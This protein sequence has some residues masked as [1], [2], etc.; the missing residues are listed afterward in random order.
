[1]S[2]KNQAR[3][4]K[5][6][7]R[8]LRRRLVLGAGLV[9]LC[10]AVGSSGPQQ[11]PP[12]AARQDAQALAEE[13]KAAVAQ[14]IESTPDAAALANEA[15][16]A[17]EQLQGATER[18]A[19]AGAALTI[20]FAA[21]ATALS[22]QSTDLTRALSGMLTPTADAPEPPASTPKTMP[23]VNSG[24]RYGAQEPP[25]SDPVDS[26]RISVD[27]TGLIDL[28]VRNAD[29]PAVLEMLS[30]QTR[31]SI[32]ASQSVTGTISANLYKAT[33]T[34]ALDAL[35][36]ANGFAYIRTSG[37]IQVGTPEEIAKRLPPPETR[38][39]RLQYIPKSEALVAAEALL[40][41]IGNALAGGGESDAADKTA[42]GIATATANATMPKA[43]GDYLIVT[44]TP[45]QLEQIGAMLSDIDVRPQQVLIEATILRATLNESNEF[46]I[47]FT[48]LGGVD[49]QT[50][51]ST[52]NTSS[53]ITTGQTPP[54][55]F[56]QTTFNIN[57]DLI[58]N[59]ANGG[60]SF[61]IIKNSIGAFVRALEEVTDVAVV[62]NPKIIALNRQ[63]AEVIVGRRDGYLTTTV[64]ETAAIQTVEFLE[65]GTQIKFRPFINPNGS[66]MLAVHPKDSNGGLTSS[67][68]P[69]E[70]TTE[71]T[72]TIIVED[73][74]T[75]LIGGLFRERNVSSKGQVPILGNIPGLGMLFQ[76]AS[77]QTLREEVIILLTVHVLKNT[78]SETEAQRKLR[79]DIERVRIGSRKGLMGFG[80]ERLAQ[81]YYQEAL[82]QFDRGNRDLALLNTRMTLHNAPRHIPALKLKERL[83]GARMWDA[84]G[85]AGR[86]FLMHLINQDSEDPDLH[87]GR[88]PLQQSLD[89]PGN[90]IPG[91][92][93]PAEEPASP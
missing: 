9:A 10:G 91:L 2:I 86:T 53:D 38:I 29:L 72:A 35:V 68:L 75:V 3:R 17:F 18:P 88:P 45:E 25:P 12:P 66:V 52:S 47:D 44:D 59:F 23:P 27:E 40:S 20:D 71:A 7:P 14:A 51:A 62:A 11:A 92:A 46:G 73:G 67:N 74:H 69:F 49:F 5:P 79:E 87:L 56:E 19:I 82:K 32:V 22:S 77:D 21:L 8:P 30:Y 4:D 26:G 60:F 42:G 34:Q 37:S 80:R 70:E 48:L 50:V 39:F 33:L 43:G 28:H 24:P 85:S 16:A 90:E 64:T 63:E 54:E 78:D 76:H 93:E 81:A 57:T 15:R 31:E 36:P 83:L 65:T 13:A 1:M 89:Q 61:G 58:N 55:K 84:D 6:P 41:P